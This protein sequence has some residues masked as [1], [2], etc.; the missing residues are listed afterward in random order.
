LADVSG[1]VNVD[2]ADLAAHG[3]DD[4]D[5]RGKVVN[6]LGSV[7][8]GLEGAGL[9]DVATH[10][11]DVQ[12]LKGWRRFL[13]PHEDTNLVPIGEQLPDQAR[14]DVP[15]PSRNRDA[16]HRAGEYSRF[17]RRG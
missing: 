1:P 3:T 5:Q 7:D 9:T 13:A 2:G 16:S 14:T 8:Q 11:L 4:R 17:A 15:T 12:A 10:Q 6:A